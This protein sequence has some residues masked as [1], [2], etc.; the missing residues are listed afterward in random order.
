MKDDGGRAIWGSAAWEALS[1]ISESTDGTTLVVVTD[2]LS[3]RA[4]GVRCYPSS[5]H[6]RSQ[7]SDIQQLFS[8]V[9]AFKPIFASIGI[10][11][12]ICIRLE[13]SSCS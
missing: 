7:L 10:M 3:P 13:G 6:A 9:L 11:A 8:M 4:S 2:V 1:L 12:G 5:R